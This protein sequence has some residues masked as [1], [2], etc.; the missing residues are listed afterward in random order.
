[1]KRRILF[2]TLALVLVMTMLLPG[3][4]LAKNDRANPNWGMT[5]FSGSGLIYVTYMPDP[6][7]KGKIWRYEGEIVEGFLAQC[8]WDLLAGTAFWSEHDSI[9]RVDDQG[10][11]NGVMKGTFSLARPDGSGVLEGT[12]TGLIRGNLYTGDISDTG[13]WVSNGGTGVF[14]G[15]KAVGKWSAELSIGPIPGTDIYTLIGPVT[16]EGMYKLPAEPPSPGKFW[17]FD[18]PDKPVKPWKVIRPD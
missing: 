11:A 12:F 5:D 15:V 14:E 1:M 2:I 9:V 6:I 7:I 17:K 13:V 3:A 8:D 16:W 4:A 10:N 18:K